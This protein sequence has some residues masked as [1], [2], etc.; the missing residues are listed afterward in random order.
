MCVL[1]VCWGG[2]VRVRCVQTSLSYTTGYLLSD[3]IPFAVTAVCLPCI[4]LIFRLSF[5]GGWWA[6]AFLMEESGWGS[7]VGLLTSGFSLPISR[8]LQGC[9]TRQTNNALT[10]LG[11]S[12]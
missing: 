11:Y 6:G 9:A 7:G 8:P 4:R 2:G 10:P 3:C 12:A 1:C 5:L